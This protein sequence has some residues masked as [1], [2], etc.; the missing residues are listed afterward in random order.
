MMLPRDGRGQTFAV[1]SMARAHDC[2]IG[3]GITYWPL[4]NVWIGV[5]V[6]DQATADERI[7]HLLRTP[8]AHRWVSA[9]PMLGAIDLI[10]WMPFDG[11]AWPKLNLVMVGGESGPRARPMH[12]DWP[13]SLRNQCAAAGVRF[14]LKQW[15]EW[16]NYDTHEGILPDRCDVD[17]GVTLWGTGRIHYGMNRETALDDGVTCVRIGTKATG[18]LLDGVEHWR[19]PWMEGHHV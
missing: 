1:R 3:S 4:P 15:G 17:H 14:C 11:S 13:R 2:E 16:G 7:P 12:P 8:A 9:E 5:S 10:G 18:R 19:V 6:S